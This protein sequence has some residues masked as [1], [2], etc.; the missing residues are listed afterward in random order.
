MMKSEQIGGDQTS[1]NKQTKKSITRSI[2]VQKV[3]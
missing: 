1:N 3:P 2:V